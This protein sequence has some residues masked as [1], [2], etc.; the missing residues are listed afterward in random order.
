[1]ENLN[2]KNIK[3]NGTQLKYIAIIAMTIDHIAWLLFPGL[4]RN[5]IAVTMH[6]IGRL[7]APIMWYFIAEG[8]YYTK[9][10][11]KYFTRLLGFAI[12]SHFAFC[13]GL[14]IPFDVTKGSLFNKTSVMF[15]L[16]MAVLLIAIFKNDKIKDSLKIMSIVALCLITF[17]ADWSSI[18]LMMPFFLYQHR[19]N[20]KHQVQDF[21]IWISVY[22]LIYIIFIDV[23]YGILQLATLLSIPLL[24]KYDGTRGSSQN[25]KW[26]FYVYFPLH[27]VIIGILR[28]LLYGNIPLVF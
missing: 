13:F 6:I 9:D 12:I 28:I 5:P 21:V 8:C 14:G 19:D 3:L 15:P 26:L 24:A 7:T 18:A 4:S 23:F 27:L 17:V 25:I 16:A 20:F 11:K 10:I 2:L 22:A 1:M